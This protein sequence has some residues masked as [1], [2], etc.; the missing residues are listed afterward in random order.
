MSHARSLSSL[1]SVAVA[2]PAVEGWGGVVAAAG[3]DKRLVLTR[4]RTVVV[5]HPHT[6]RRKAAVN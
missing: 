4:P 2:G 6:P 1:E 5:G 3:A